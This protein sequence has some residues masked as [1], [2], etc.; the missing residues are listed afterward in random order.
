MVRVL[1]Y[2]SIGLVGMMAMILACNEPEDILP[3]KDLYFSVEF[4]DSLELTQLVNYWQNDSVFE[5]E[6]NNEI[7][8][9]NRLISY[10]GGLK[11]HQKNRTLVL[12]VF[13]NRATALD[14]LD[15]Y[16]SSTLVNFYTKADSVYIHSNSEGVAIIQN[17]YNTLIELIV[18]R[19]GNEQF[20]AEETVSGL[21]M[22]LEAVVARIEEFSFDVS[23]T[24]IE[25]DAN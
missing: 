20:N 4:I 11:L 21:M 19:K 16:F 6:R 7:L 12:T 18:A 1:H 25:N 8:V 2:I 9:Y 15:Y 17:K 24:K 10:E 22:N 23:S 13:K 14:A 5:I 3:K